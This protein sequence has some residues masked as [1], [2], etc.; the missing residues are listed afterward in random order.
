MTTLGIALTVIIF[1]MALRVPVAIS[2]GLAAMLATAVELGWRVFPISA[3]VMVDGVSSFVLF[4]A[5]FFM[6]AGEIM[7]RGGLTS[8][9]FRLASTLV[10]WMPGG[11]GQVNVLASMLFAGNDR[12][13]DFR[14]CRPRHNG[15]QG[16]ARARL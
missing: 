2:I 10:G 7:N 5:P 15:D 16:N 12:L 13:R 1:L 11:L 6:L 9:I 4:A 3:Q 14:C 8:R